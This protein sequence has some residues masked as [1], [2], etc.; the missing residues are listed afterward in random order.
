MALAEI[1][2]MAVKFMQ[3]YGG[4][5]EVGERVMELRLTYHIVSNEAVLTRRQDI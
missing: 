1:K 2:V 4:L 3:R 5:R